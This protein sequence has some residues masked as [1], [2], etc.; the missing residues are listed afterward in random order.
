[1][2]D[3][4]ACRPDGGVVVVDFKTGARRPGDRRQLGAY[5]NAVRSLFPGARVDGL[6]VYAGAAP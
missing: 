4:L 6:L 3:C 5:V 2:I 1:V